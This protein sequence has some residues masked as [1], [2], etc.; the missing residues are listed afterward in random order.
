LFL[1]CIQKNTPH[2]KKDQ[3]QSSIHPVEHFT[4]VIYPAKTYAYCVWQKH[5]Q[6]GIQFAIGRKCLPNKWVGLAP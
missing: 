6:V 1:V 3:F 4:K 5:A 2:K